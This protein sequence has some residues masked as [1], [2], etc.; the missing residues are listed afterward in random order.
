MCWGYRPRDSRW[1][2]VPFQPSG[3]A[4]S[5]TNPA[6]WSSFD[7]VMAAYRS[8]RFDGIGIALDGQK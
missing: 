2:K 3:R 5:P 6:T 8:G 4:A 7:A 1:T